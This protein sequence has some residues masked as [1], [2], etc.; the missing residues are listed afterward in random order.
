MNFMQWQLQHL[1]LD[2][3]LSYAPQPHTLA[4]A[5]RK[6]R[7]CTCVEKNFLKKKVQCKIDATDSVAETDRLHP[8]SARIILTNLDA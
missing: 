5:A 2:Q 8:A 3:T 4:S 1:S 7:V 6:L